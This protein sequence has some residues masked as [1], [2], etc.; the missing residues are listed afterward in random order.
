[1]TEFV[2]FVVV[3]I[4]VSLITK[5]RQKSTRP[6]GQPNPKMQALIERLQAQQGLN[7]PPQ[8]HQGQF[9]QPAAP[10]QPGVPQQPGGYAPPAQYQPAPFQQPVQYQQPGQY[11]QPV[12]YQQRPPGHVPPQNNLPRPKQDLDAQVRELMK[13][14][15]EVG[16]IRLL[17]DERDLGI[18]AAQ[19]YAR[20]LVAPT[21]KPAAATPAGEEPDQDDTRYIGSAAISES[22]FNLDDRDENV[23]AS[24]WVDK[25][26]PDDRSDI[27]ELWQTVGNPPRPGATPPKS[28]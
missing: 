13:A 25:P 26:E 24:G 8:Q 2:I 6:N 23:W 5:A 27:D 21:A 16:A 22:I 3:M 14:G 9:T 20:S 7:Q 19:E 11:Q 12:Q 1:M 17:S 28:Q 4:V 15:N 18:L 10:Q